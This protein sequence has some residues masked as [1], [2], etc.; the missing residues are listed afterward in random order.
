MGTFLTAFD[1]GYIS[2]FIGKSLDEIAC[3]DIYSN[4]DDD[5]DDDV[6]KER[7][8]KKKTGPKPSKLPT[9]IDM[10]MIV[11]GENELENRKLVL[12]LQN[13]QQVKLYVERKRKQIQ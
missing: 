11:L 3:E 5:D 1:N 6:G 9:D 12:S 13:S 8:R 7:A 2:K 4:D 10:G